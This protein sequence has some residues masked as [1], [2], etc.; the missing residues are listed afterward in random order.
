MKECPSCGRN[1]DSD[2]RFCPMDGTQLVESAQT[3]T[4]LR[5]GE[6]RIPKP[7]QPLPMR[8]TIVDQGDDGRRS[9]VIQGWFTT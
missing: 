1:Y 9:R 5:R 3:R 4:T 2:K 7:P 6:R 8:L